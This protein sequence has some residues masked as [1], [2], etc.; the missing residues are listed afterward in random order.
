MRSTSLYGQWMRRLQLF[1]AAPTAP[2]TRRR[3]AR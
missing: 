1:L 3:P 2:K